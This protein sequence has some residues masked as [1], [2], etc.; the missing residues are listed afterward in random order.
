MPFVCDVQQPSRPRLPRSLV[1]RTRRER[2]IP[3]LEANRRCRWRRH[4]RPLKKRWRSVFKSVPS[5]CP[6]PRRNK[7]TLSNQSASGNQRN[8]KHDQFS[9]AAFELE[10]LL[11]DIFT[12]PLDHSVDEF[13][14]YF[15]EAFNMKMQSPLFAPILL[16]FLPLLQSLLLLFL[17]FV[18]GL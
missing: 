9:R 6:H 10:Q 1:V 7:G 11:A 2:L 5:C 4:A 8:F 13:A 3:R 18:L 15:C 17:L 12:R 16:F 14:K